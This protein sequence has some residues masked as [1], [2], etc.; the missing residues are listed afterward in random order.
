MHCEIL[1]FLSRLVRSNNRLRPT[2]SF[3]SIAAWRME[4]CRIKEQAKYRS[5]DMLWLFLFGG[6]TSLQF[7]L[8]ARLLPTGNLRI[9]CCPATADARFR[10]QTAVRGVNGWTSFALWPVEPRRCHPTPRSGPF[11]RL[12]GT[13][14]RKCR[15]LVFDS[16]AAA[17]HSSGEHHR[18]AQ[19]DYGHGFR[20]GGWRVTGIADTSCQGLS[21]ACGIIMRD[22]QRQVIDRQIKR[23]GATRVAE[24]EV[25][26]G[27]KTDSNPSLLGVHRT[28]DCGIESGVSNDTV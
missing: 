16:P 25:L 20:N 11:S 12:D 8:A 6:C 22:I 17:R 23:T 14:R 1:P 27:L 21:Y 24:S 9:D 10:L 15:K 2:T 19:Q 26:G 28:R 3:Q 5:G 18:R 13:A 7:A 4:V